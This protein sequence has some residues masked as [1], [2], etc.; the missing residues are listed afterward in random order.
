[1]LDL[2]LF[3]NIFFFNIGPYRGDDSYFEWKAKSYYKA[4]FFDIRLT[5][6]APYKDIFYCVAKEDLKLVYI[7]KKETVF[8]IGANPIVQS[9]LLEALIEYLINEFF[10]TYDESLLMTCY[11]DSN[12]CPI[13]EGFRANTKYAFE[14]YS[15]LDLVKMSRVTCKGC[16]KTLNIIIKKSTIEKSQKPTTPIVYVH[17]GHALLVY[18][19]KQYKVRGAELVS[20]SY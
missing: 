15:T 11:A 14:N 17:S 19:D 16:N 2:D 13:F 5:R 18:V 3:E 12:T 9:Q 8:T 10:E 20:I 4:S 1:M 7:V 6:N